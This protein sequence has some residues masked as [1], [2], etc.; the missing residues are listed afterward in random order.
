MLTV[1]VL[2]PAALSLATILKVDVVA[3]ANV[4]KLQVMTLLLLVQLQ[5]VL[6]VYDTKLALVGNVAVSTKVEALSVAL[7]LVTVMP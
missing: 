6:V 3:C 1:L 7:L 5:P 4:D 2:L